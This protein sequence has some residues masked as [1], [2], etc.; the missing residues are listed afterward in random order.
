M[1]IIKQRLNLYTT[2]SKLSTQLPEHRIPN[3]Q[4]HWNPRKNI[5]N[6]GNPVRSWV[7][8]QSQSLFYFSP[9]E[10]ESFFVLG[11]CL[12]F[13]FLMVKLIW[14]AVLCQRNGRMSST[15]S[16]SL[17][18]CEFSSVIYAFSQIFVWFYW[19]MTRVSSEYCDPSLTRHFRV[20]LRELFFPVVDTNFYPILICH[21]L[22]YFIVNSEWNYKFAPRL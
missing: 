22:F 2:K 19:R 20:N 11:N 13:N 14:W 21:H 9:G 10:N 17:S 4:K 18:V 5:K 12:I 6:K 15:D 1:R 16:P 3:K 8:R 7:N